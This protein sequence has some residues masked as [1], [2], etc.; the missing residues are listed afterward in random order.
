MSAL[1]RCFLQ[2]F[3]VNAAVVL[4]PNVSVTEEEVKQVLKSSLA[5]FK[6]PQR[7]FFADQVPK[8][9]TGKIQRRFVAKHFLEAEASKSTAGPS[10]SQNLP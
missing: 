2:S 1:V 9:A 10:E 4:R 6:I 3:Q 5:P 8:T 7:I